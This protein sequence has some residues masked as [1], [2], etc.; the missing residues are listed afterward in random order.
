MNIVVF[1]ANCIHIYK[2]EYKDYTPI[3]KPNSPY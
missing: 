3:R 1:I 2:C